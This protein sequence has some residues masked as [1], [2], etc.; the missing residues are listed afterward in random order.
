[1]KSALPKV[2]LSPAPV[3]MEKCQDQYTDGP[4]AEDSGWSGRRVGADQFDECAEQAGYRNR[5]G[6]KVHN[7]PTAG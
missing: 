4:D 2:K 6:E 7:L 3:A 5:R 1:M